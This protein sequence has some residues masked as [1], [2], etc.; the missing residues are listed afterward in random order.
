[1]V[2]NIDNTGSNPNLRKADINSPQAG[3]GAYVSSNADDAVYNA[4]NWSESTNA[5]NIV[6]NQIM[7]TSQQQNQDYQAQMNN[8]LNSSSNSS[9]SSSTSANRNIRNVNNLI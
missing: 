7:Q 9:S 5:Q 6:E 3:Q 4:V 8:I 1:M 2:N